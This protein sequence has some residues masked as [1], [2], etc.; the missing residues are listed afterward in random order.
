MNLS[1]VLCFLF[2]RKEVRVERRVVLT[3]LYLHSVL[4]MVSFVQWG[5]EN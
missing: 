3:Q 5:L 2:L 4:I 1:T